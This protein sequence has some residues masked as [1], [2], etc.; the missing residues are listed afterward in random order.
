AAQRADRWRQQQVLFARQA[1]E[2]AALFG[3]VADAQMGDPVGGQVDGLGPLDAHR[4]LAG[5]REPEDGSEGRGASRAVAAQQGH[6]LALAD[7]EVDAVQYMRF[8]IPGVEI[9]DL[10]CGSAHQ[11]APW[12]SPLVVPM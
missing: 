9:A 11:W 7:A 1:G 10:E 4:A 5:P 8:A 6:D 12:S 3:A 2:D